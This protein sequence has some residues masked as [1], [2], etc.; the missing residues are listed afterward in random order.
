[1]KIESLAIADVKLI[2][3]R[4]IRDERGFF[5]ETWN[6]QDLKDAG[7]DAKFVQ[8]NH[9]L[10]R[11]KFTVRGLHFQLAPKGQGKLIRC[12]RG[13]I[14]DVAVDIR[15]SSPTYGQ[16]VTA[17]LS[18]ANWAQLWLPIG[19]AHGYATLEPDTE[20]IYKVTEYYSPALDRGIAWDD[21]ALAIQW[22]VA[23][24]DA[25]LSGKDKMQPLLADAP[26]VF[27]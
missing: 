8:D 13:A 19:F 23:A 14:L 21:P 25:E 5:S 22:P 16:H 18:S 3:P 26:V 7:I 6:A 27:D 9:A 2:T 1:M 15:K 24:R 20:V 4:I 17:V 11:A 10:S 12:V